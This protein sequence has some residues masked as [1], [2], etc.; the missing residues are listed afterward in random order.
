[1]RTNSPGRN[2]GDEVIETRVL[3]AL[4]AMEPSKRIHVLAATEGMAQAFPIPA[5][6]KPVLSLV[7]VNG[8]LLKKAKCKQSKGSQS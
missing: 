5:P 3:A 8:Q 2:A 1:M 4:R 7:A 6:P